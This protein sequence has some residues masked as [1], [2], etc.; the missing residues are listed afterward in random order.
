M[1]IDGTMVGDYYDRLDELYEQTG[2]DHIHHGYWDPDR[3]DVNRV[4]AADTLVERVVTVGGV[5]AGGR[6]LDAGC[7]V[8]GTAVFLADRLD[9]AVDGITISARQIERAERKAAD[10]GVGDRTRF[11]LVDAENTDYP[12][13]T[14]DAVVALESCEAM[15]DKRRFLAECH[16][17]LRPGGRLVVATWCRARTDLGVDDEGLLAKVRQDFYLADVLP[18][19]DYARICADVGF[20]D[21]W[22]EDWTE[23]VRRTWSVADP[24]NNRDNP[25][26]LAKLVRSGGL[27][28]VRFAESWRRMKQCYDRDVI[29]YG[30]FGGIHAERG[31]T[32][33]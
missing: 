23:N 6:V 17:V 2:G 30:V 16:R 12:D 29:R 1:E 20:A 32:R 26:Y 27:D 25:G 4:T 22:S 21:V 28:F 7:G 15:P 10:A 3:P 31:E 33:G 8:G 5:P 18:L 11:R 14:F 19:P 24:A 13:G 9:C